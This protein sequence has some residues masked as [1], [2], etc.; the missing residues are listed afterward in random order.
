VVG[1]EASEGLSRPFE[2][3]LAAPAEVSVDTASLVGAP[4]LLTVQLGDGRARFFLGEVSSLRTWDAGAGPQRRRYRAKVEPRLARLRHTQKSSPQRRHWTLRRHQRQEQLWWTRAGGISV[5]RGSI[6]PGSSSASSRWTCSPA[7]AAVPHPRPRGAPPPQAHEAAGHPAAPGPGS[8]PSP[9]R[10]LALTPP[11]ASPLPSLHRPTPLEACAMGG[12][13]PD[14][15][16]HDAGAALN[17]PIYRPRAR[18]ARTP[19]C[20]PH[21]RGPAGWGRVFTL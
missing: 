21:A 4:A 18:R 11:S 14:S 6:G 5:P 2:V 16:P 9:A 13:R 17:P 1:F 12:M 7:Q 20:A 10:L 15:R 19:T 8:G 3:D